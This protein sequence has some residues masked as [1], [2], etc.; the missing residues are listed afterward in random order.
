VHEIPYDL[1]MAVQSTQGHFHGF[2]TATFLKSGWDDSHLAPLKN[3]I[4][5]PASLYTGP[6]HRKVADAVL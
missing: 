4:L 5:A 2:K 6:V 1:F 3:T